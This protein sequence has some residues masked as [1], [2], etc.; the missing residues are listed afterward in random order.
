MGLAKR[1]S[2]ERPAVP[3]HL[4]V[5]RGL[6]LRRETPLLNLLTVLVATVVGLAP[7]AA[8]SLVEYRLTGARVMEGPE[9]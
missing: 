7:P 3:P 9:R 4:A 1:P 5:P 8:P 6:F 2:E